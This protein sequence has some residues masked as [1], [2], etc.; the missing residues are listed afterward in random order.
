MYKLRRVLFCRS[1]LVILEQ[2][3]GCCPIWYTQGSHFVHTSPEH[4]KDSSRV[5]VYHDAELLA[6]KLV[7]ML[8]VDEMAEAFLLQLSRAMPLKHGTLVDHVGRLKTDHYAG[9]RVLARCSCIGSQ[10]LYQI[11]Y[12]GKTCHCTYTVY[13][14]LKSV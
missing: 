13:Q 6:C 14:E 10:P 7:D 5:C 12:S 1:R 9:S 8:F 4:T 11:N 2:L 3:C